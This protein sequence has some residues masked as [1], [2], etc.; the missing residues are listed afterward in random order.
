MATVVLPK[1]SWLILT[2]RCNNRCQQCYY[3]IEQ[4]HSGDI[5]TGDIELFMSLLK[6]LE[7]ENCVLI[8]GE[9]TLY[10]YLEDAIRI[11]R[12][13]GIKISIVTNGS[14]Y[15]NK[16]RLKTSLENGLHSYSVSIEGPNAKLHDFQTRREGSFTQATRAIVNGLELGARV[17]SIT[18]ISQTTKDSAMEIYQAM[19]SLGVSTIVYNV[20]TP[21]LDR[22]NRNCLLP[23]AET[24]QILQNLFLETLSDVESSKAKVKLVTPLPLCLFDPKLVPIMK[25]TGF[26]RQGCGCQMLYGCHWIGCSLGNIKTISG[27]QSFPKPEDFKAWWFKKEPSVFRQRL[28]SYPSQRCQNCQ[29]WGNSCVG[30]CPLLWLEFNASECIP[31]N[32]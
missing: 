2:P 31:D 32:R 11:G 9:P 3:G 8:G 4:F 24:A 28:I 10:P 19:R 18:T 23:I 1:V 7:T 13:Q 17:A 26:L 29:F 22:S 27:N 14:V 15:A 30:G 6:E 20:C 25:K 21:S 12:L 16:N 5:S